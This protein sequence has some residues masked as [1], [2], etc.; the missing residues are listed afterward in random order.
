MYCVVVAIVQTRAMA[1]KTSELRQ[2]HQAAV[3]GLLKRYMQL[4]SEVTSY[5]KALESVMATQPAGSSKHRG[6]DVSIRDQ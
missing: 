4:R 6:S 2:K 1:E 3:A 5:N